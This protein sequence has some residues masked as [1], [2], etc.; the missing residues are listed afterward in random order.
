MLLCCFFAF[1]FVDFFLKKEALL[2]ND[3]TFIF[4]LYTLYIHP[5]WF[6]YCGFYGDK[7]TI[8]YVHFK[9]RFVFVFFFK[10]K[11]MFCYTQHF[12]EHYPMTVTEKTAKNYG[13]IHVLGFQGKATSGSRSS[14]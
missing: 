1:C 4:L 7:V 5:C 6:V 10:R 3:K 9:S 14:Y 2:L 12:M 8:S 11:N 13:K